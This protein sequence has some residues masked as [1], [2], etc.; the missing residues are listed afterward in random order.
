MPTMVKPRRQVGGSMPEGDTEWKGSLLRP[1]KTASV[2]AIIL[3]SWALLLNFLNIVIGVHSEGQKVRWIEFIT[4]G[5][6]VSQ[7]HEIGILLPDD[8][9]FGL[10]GIGIFAAG[11]MGI[12]RSVEGG[13]AKWFSELPKSAIFSSLLSTDNGSSRTI[14]SWMIVSGLLFYFVWSVLNTTWVDPGV[15]S[16]MIALVAFGFG[17]H[18][19]E[20]S[21]ANQ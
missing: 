18:S 14:G 21:G 8:L 5:S 2:V 20:D 1:S 15:Y 19:I 12:G 17:L 13:F 3:G 4:N 16:V 11:F 6:E 10:M 9:V 7:A